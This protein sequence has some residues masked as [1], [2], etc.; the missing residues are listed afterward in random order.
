M[1]QYRKNKNLSI[2]LVFVL[3]LF[4]F[5]CSRE[6]S[7][8]GKYHCPM[9]PTYIADRPGECPICGMKLVPIETKTEPITVPKYACPMHPEVT[10]DKPDQRCPKCGMKLEP[11]ETKPAAPAK[12]VCP[13]HPEVTSDKP[14]QKCPKC[15]MKLELVPRETPTPGEAAPTPLGLETMPG[16]VMTPLPTETANSST[17]SARSTAEVKPGERK[18]LFYRNPMD[19]SVTSPV[20]AKDSMGMDY[21]P[22]YA[23]ETASTVNDVSGFASISLNESERKLAGVQVAEATLDRLN[24]TTRT[25]GAVQAD[26]S[27][28]RHIHTKI[29]GYIEKLFIN[30]T[31]QSVKKGAPALSIYSPELLA[32]QQEFLQAMEISRRFEKSDIPE[33]RKGGEDLLQ[34]SRRRL[35]LFDVPESLIDDLIKNK[36]PQR[37]VTLNAPVSGFVTSK[38]IFEGQQVEPG[39]E[40]FTVTDLSRVWIEADFYEYEARAVRIGQ[41]AKLSFPYDPAMELQ[42]RVSYI[43]PYLNPE[44]RTLK[45]RFDFDNAK[46]LLKP[47]MYVDVTL[48]ID[49]GESVVVPESAVMDTGLRKMVFVQQSDAQLTP[50]DIKAGVTSEGKTQILSGLKAGEKVVIQANFLIDSESRLRAAIQNMTGK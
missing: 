50:R 14:D 23:E 28:I 45:V 40:L 20:P 8:G 29:A 33:V 3:L 44:S 4:T 49:A 17:Q 48:Q 7:D 15:G 35:E 2:C 32:S 13:M 25:V 31:G 18:I 9:H 27:R 21:V 41:E 38:D 39:M 26:E 24:F 6:K 47:A 12:Y 10:S 22:V 19:P 37:A 34:S 5:A 46:L 1:T 11:I 42:G 30:F 36:K 16:M 43:Y